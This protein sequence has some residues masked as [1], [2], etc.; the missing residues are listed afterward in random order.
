MNNKI[1]GVGL[2][3]LGYVIIILSII[4]LPRYEN[5]IVLAVLFGALGGSLAANGNFYMRHGKL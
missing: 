5:I 3:I 4:F 2:Q 1:I